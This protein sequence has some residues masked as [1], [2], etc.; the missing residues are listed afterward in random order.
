MLKLYWKEIFVFH[1]PLSLQ[2][3]LDTLQE[4]FADGLGTVKDVK[5]AI[6]FEAYATPQI[7]I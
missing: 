4:V 5:A 3:V 1:S 7:C 6:H 2:S